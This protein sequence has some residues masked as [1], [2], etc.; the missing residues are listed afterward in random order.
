MA[1][2]ANNDFWISVQDLSLFLQIKPEELR[3]EL[4]EKS[5][6]KFTGQYV[7]PLRVKNILKKRDIKIP[8]QVVSVQMLK[9]GVAKTT[10]VMNLGL[11]AAMYGAKVLFV[12]LDQQAN[13]TYALGYDEE[14]P[15]VWIDIVEKKKNIKDCIVT[16]EDHI[17]LIPSSLNNSVLDK[18]LMNSNRN[19]SSAVKSPLESIASNYDLIIIDTAPALSAINTAVC[20]ASDMIILPVNPD[21]FSMLGLDKNLSELKEIKSDFDLKFD[22]KILFTKFDGREKMSHEI[23]QN[24]IEKYEDLLMQSYIRTSSEAK[25]S[26]RGAKNIFQGKS[27][28]KEDYDL[29][30][31]ELLQFNTVESE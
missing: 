30:T 28:V 24:C 22:T 20:V 2:I 23:L 27:S 3:E 25:N 11:R 10:S 12:D 5:E 13:L 16:I 7:P 19:W 26:I 4:S 1:Q 9:G 17:D 14:N 18:V 21:R 6:Q 29:V 31:R 15:S 8:K